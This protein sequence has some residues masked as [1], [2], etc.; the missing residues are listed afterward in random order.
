[1]SSSTLRRVQPLTNFFSNSK[2]DP[3]ADGARFLASGPPYA[4]YGHPPASSPNASS[5]S[6]GADLE[7]NTAPMHH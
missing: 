1:M 5:L 6:A 7:A 2:F 3:E 4:P